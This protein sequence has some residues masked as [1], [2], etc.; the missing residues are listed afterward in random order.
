MLS[1]LQTPALIRRVF[2]VA[3]LLNSI[4]LIGSQ[5]ITP[6]APLTS[7]EQSDTTANS[8]LPRE[9]DGRSAELLSAFF[10]LD[11]G[12]PL[13]AEGVCRGAGGLM[14]C[15]LSFPTKLMLI[16]YSPVTFG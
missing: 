10:G 9:L 11:N 1:N 3:L 8:D 14:A 7:T 12:L 4:V 6:A 15:P 16:P 5:R 13:Q 2:I